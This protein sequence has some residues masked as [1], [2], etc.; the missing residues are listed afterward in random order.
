MD[1]HI[2]FVT[3]ELASANTVA[4]GLATFTANMAHIF[5]ENGH[6]VSIILASTKEIVPNIEDG[7]HL[8]PFHVPMKTWKR[9]DAAAG[10]LSFF[11]KESRDRLRRA[12]IV[13]YKSK[14]TQ[15]IV[16]SIHKKNPIDIIHYSHHNPINKKC[17]R[18]I[19]YIVRLSSLRNIWTEA[20]MPECNLNYAYNKSSLFSRDRIE[21]ISIKKARYVVA[22]SHLLADIATNNLGVK[23]TVIESPFVLESQDWNYSCLE[24][25]GLKEKKYII[26]YGGQLRYF[27]GTHTVAKLANELLYKYPDLYLVLA[28]KCE[29]MRDGAGNVVKAHELVKQGAG[30]YAERV[31]YVGQ[32]T[33]EKLYPL[34]QYAEVCLLPSRIENL[35]NACI[36][37]MAMGKMVVATDGASYEQLIDNRISGFLCERDNPGSFLRG[38]EEALSMSEEEKSAMGNKAIEVTQRLRPDKIY[39]KYLEFYEKVIRDW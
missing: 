3:T 20:N 32:L 9:M 10:M 31:I 1:M 23:V 29:D 24:Q 16:H 17:I 11:I 27:K 14:V 30:E 13:K 6:R 5:K 19:P 39:E 38:I 21:E 8:Y 7:I 15:K 22:P 26:H 12:I 28:G 34:I 37:A 33:R 18:N 4:G 25:Y 36:E 2:V 35:A